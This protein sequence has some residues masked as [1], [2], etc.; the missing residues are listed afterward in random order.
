MFFNNYHS[1]YN[2]KYSCDSNLS[3]NGINTVHLNE[4]YGVWLEKKM[5]HYRPQWN[6]MV[7]KIEK[8]I[9][10][11]KKIALCIVVYFL[12]GSYFEK[13]CNEIF[14]SDFYFFC[15]NTTES[16]IESI[17]IKIDNSIDFNFVVD[18]KK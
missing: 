8:I 6:A 17:L 9:P 10:A 5:S 4:N 3:F 2:K 7:D 13:I 16:D 11:Y 12:I 15:M 14:E 18:L 1:D